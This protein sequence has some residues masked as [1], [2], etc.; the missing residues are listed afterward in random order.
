VGGALKLIK[1]Q[2]MEVERMTRDSRRLRV[3][4][5]SFRARDFNNA[6]LPQN[7]LLSGGFAQNPYL[8]NKVQQ[9]ARSRPSQIQV[10]T[11]DDW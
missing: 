9:Y 3:T 11:A 6:Y 2:V 4:V 7:I 8:R 1:K 5:S 10:H